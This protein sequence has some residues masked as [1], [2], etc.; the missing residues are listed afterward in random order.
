MEKIVEHSSISMYEQDQ[1]KYSI[2]VN[3]RRAFP[4]VRDGLKPVQRRVIYGAFKDGLTRPSKKDKSASLVG[5]VMKLYH[6]HGDSS[7]YDAITCLTNW[8]KIKMPIFYGKGN[9]GNVSGS[10]AA[11]MRYTECALSDFGYDVLIEELVQS[12]NV[13]D[14]IKTYKR[15]DVEPEFLPAKVP[16]LLINGSFGIGVGMTINVPSHNLVEVL[17]ATRALLRDESIDI[18]LVP[19]LCQPCTLIDTDWKIIC[20]T[21]RGSFKVRGNIITETDKKGNTILRITSLPD[22]VTTTAV[23]DKILSMIEEKQ[24]PMIKDIFNALSD[25]RPDIV[26]HLKPGADAKYGKQIIYAKTDVKVTVSVNFEAVD[27][28]GRDTKR[29]SYKE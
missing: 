29:F 27:I 16:L 7:I 15:D 11:A 25:E 4:E 24:L 10:G 18:V 19:D 6:P 28:N 17:E 23:Y 1:T 3:R 9:W 22:M 26:I 20:D 5:T 13:V 14:W 2:V 21:G 8:F 12:P